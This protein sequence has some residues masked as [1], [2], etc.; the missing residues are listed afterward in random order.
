[1]PVTKTDMKLFAPATVA[2]SFSTANVGGA[3][4]A[5]QVSGATLNEIF[6]TMAANAAA[7]GDRVQHA[8]I[9]DKN[10]HA[11]D[12]IDNYG[13]WLA[14]ALDDLTTSSVI[15][16]VSTSAS[17]DATKKVRL[18]GFNASGDVIQEEVALNGTS[19][20]TGTLSFSQA[21]SGQEK[22]RVEVRLVSGGALT[23]AAGEIT[24]THNSVSI[25]VVPAT[26]KTA[27][28]EIDIGI[29]AAIGGSSVIALASTAPSGITFTRP[30]TAATKIVVDGGT[31]T[32]EFG[33]AQ[34]IWLRWTLNETMNPSSK[35]QNAIV[36]EGDAA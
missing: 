35:I 7:G 5:T 30:R 12:Q 10:D 14:N 17:D 28:N 1:M 13:I 23:T 29:E 24:V 6:F 11:S 19:T 4:S 34:G 20:V 15:S 26:L 8:K 22:L 25:G 2:T 31:G 27:T 21:V 3:I 16:L 36:G 18:I 33:E 32:L 9:F